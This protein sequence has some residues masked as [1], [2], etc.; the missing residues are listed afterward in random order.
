MKLYLYIYF[1]VLLNKILVAQY[2]Q[3]FTYD[4]ENGAP[5]NEIYSITQDAHGFLWLG[6]DAGLYKY[7]GVRY[8]SYHC[9]T[10][11]TKSITGLTIASSGKLYCHNFNSQIFVIDND[12]LRELKNLSP[13]LITSIT[14][15]KKGNIFINHS[16]GIDFYNEQQK[17]WKTYG[18]TNYEFAITN[19]YYVTK[20]PKSNP[21]NAI[22]FL[23]YNGINSLVKEKVKTF[24][25][26]IFKTLSPG[27]FHAEYHRQ[28]LWIFSAENNLIYKFT[29]QKLEQIKNVNLS[30]LLSNRKITNIRSLTDGK[31]WICTYKG[32]ICFDTQTNKIDL[33]YPEKSFS[34]CLIDREGN[35]W[36][37]TLQNGLLRIPSLNM[38]V[39]NR[40]NELLKHDKIAKITSGDS[41]IYFAT[42]N[43]TI[44]KLNTKTNSLN[45]FHTSM[46][47]DVQSLDY[48]TQTSTLWFNINNNLFSLTKNE[49]KQHNTSTSAI[50][51]IKACGEYNFIGTSHGLYINNKKIKSNWSREIEFDEIHNIVWVASNNGLL[52]FVQQPN[53]EWIALITLLEGQQV[54]S[55]DFDKETETIYALSFNGNVYAISTNAKEQLV[56]T[57]PNKT[58]CFKIKYYQK[59]LYLASNKGL[60]IYNIKKNIWQTY[61]KLSGLAS[62]NVQSLVISNGNIWLATGKGVQKISLNEPMDSVRAKLFLKKIIA[63]NAAVNNIASIQ[64][65]YGDQLLLYPE[66]SIYKSNGNFKYAYRINTSDTSWIN[67]PG[68]ID[69]IDI[70]NLPSGNFEIELK[71]KDHLGFDSENQ[72]ILSGTVNPPFWKNVWF[73]IFI[74]L[75]IIAIMLSVFRARLHQIQIKQQK[76]IERINLENELRLSRET[77]LK[78][79]MNPHFVFNVLN[80]IKAYIYKNDKQKASEYLNDFSSLIRTF[81]SMS[82]QPLISLAEEL[83][84][85]KL[86]INM[87]A[88][89]LNEDFSYQQNIDDGIDLTHTKIPSLIIQPFIENVFKHGLHHKKGEKKLTLNIQQKNHDIIINIIDNGIGRKASHDI[90]KNEKREYESFAT[91]AI[92]KRIE[93]INKEKSVV[94]V[95]IDDLHDGNI[96]TGTKVTIKILC[97]D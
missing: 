40:E 43:G 37:S 27:L 81:L 57:I 96:A 52:K 70:L 61:N 11:K 15:D 86:Y 82:N 30:A 23:N 33:F 36:F 35:F 80:S 55:I 49:I 31:L 66:A 79:Q 74:L 67:L 48:D 84:M 16:G 62:D 22:F 51:T 85:L 25:T 5:S 29:N 12:T 68:T 94:T 4:D 77:A 9:K 44:G 18:I 41:S 45:T 19:N 28:S 95:S 14:S 76:K 47:G 89:Q 20:S 65:N 50:K 90:Q 63:G 75:C 88:M 56:C 71:V 7:D 46:H 97:Y 64:L 53:K 32:I 59:Q 83:K 92:Q 26:N 17:N 10:Q 78:S 21:D 73:I 13:S 54:L 39:W 3:H 2:P 34:D 38:L 1:F 6:S 60:W 24:I 42:V 91:T 8:T 58:Q 72:I 87:E 93:L 69:V